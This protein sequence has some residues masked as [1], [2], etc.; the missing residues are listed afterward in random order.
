M[1]NRSESD[2]FSVVGHWLMYASNELILIGVMLCGRSIGEVFNFSVLTLKFLKPSSEQVSNGI[3][4]YGLSTGRQLFCSSSS[5]VSRH[6]SSP[7]SASSVAKCPS[8]SSSLSSLSAALQQSVSSSVSQLHGRLLSRRSHSRRHSAHSGSVSEQSVVGPSEQQLP[9]C[10]LD[11]S[12]VKG[13]SHLLVVQYI[14][15]R[16]DTDQQL[17][18]YHRQVQLNM[19]DVRHGLQS[20]GDLLMEAPHWSV[21]GPGP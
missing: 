12:D 1:V 20:R 18:G 19:A 4:G 5:P 7:S 15:L 11:E 13:N 10:R 16:Q 8:V 6:S 14:N 9:L 2:K 21:L 3:V 17:F